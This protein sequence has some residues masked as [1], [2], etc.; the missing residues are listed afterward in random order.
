MPRS[1]LVCLALALTIGPSLA[2]QQARKVIVRKDADVARA[3]RWVAAVLRHEPGVVDGQVEEI[4]RWT[5]A[6]IEGI[7]I[8]LSVIRRLIRNNR[9]NIFMMPG[10]GSRAPLPL[11]YEEPQLEAL[12]AL[13]LDVR[14][15]GLDQDDLAT[16]G[17]LLHTDVALF[18]GGT[19]DV[20]NFADGDDRG[21]R[22]NADHWGL[23]R[24]LATFLDERSGRLTDIGA[25]YRATLAT[26]T[27][28]EFWNLSHA[29]AAVAQPPNDA[30]VLFHAASH[31][32]TLATPAVQATIAR[33]RLPGELVLRV[34][35]AE[36]E[37]QLA[38]SLLRRAVDRSPT[39][40]EARIHY[41][42]VLTLLD[43]A[44]DALPYLRRAAADATEPEQRYYASLFLGA[45][46]EAANRHDEAR[47]A[48][49]SAAAL[50]PQ[51]QS[52][53]LALSLLAMGA[54]DRAAGMRAIEP[55]LA[56]PQDE[57]RRHDPWWSYARSTGRQA[58]ALMQQAR[59][60][61]A[62]R[63][64]GQAPP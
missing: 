16:H 8:E 61:L 62:M 20:L 53:H 24:A 52:P 9:E 6:D 33:T 57:S 56:L 13:A 34:R 39:H 42:R 25:W 58:D 2:G 5:A 14:R 15:A 36:A 12:R 60:R 63:R 29:D 4:A 19:G 55:V 46:A 64:G 10:A 43:R 51:A 23:A 27:A 3:E 31:H 26:M 11:V 22:R 54:G 59:A 32:E 7:A 50:F 18:G 21:V 48:Y 38:A 47:T 37:R 40:S 45:A 30:E 44:G 28:A 35:S 41:G 1:L 49:L 17:I